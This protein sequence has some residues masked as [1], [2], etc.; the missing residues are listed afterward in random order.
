MEKEVAVLVLR[1]SISECH[2]WSCLPFS[3]PGTEPIY[4]DSSRANM[5]RW[6]I[7]SR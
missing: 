4:L 2:W 5:N 6:G 7:G 1:V 3:P